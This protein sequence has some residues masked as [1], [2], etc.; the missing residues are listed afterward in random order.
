M[1]MSFDRL[2][3]GFLPEDIFVENT[4]LVKT[5]NRLFVGFGLG[6]EMLFKFS[7][8]NIL[9]NLVIN[10]FDGALAQFLMPRNGQG[11]S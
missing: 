9:S 8:S 1:T 10:G 3:S 11:L 6:I 2:P 4:N 7:F 5:K